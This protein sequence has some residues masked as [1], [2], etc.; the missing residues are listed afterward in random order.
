MRA[1]PASSN[2]P[3]RITR[4]TRQG[5][6]R[7]LSVNRHLR[8]RGPRR[9]FTEAVAPPWATLSPD[10]PDNAF[11]SVQPKRGA[12]LLHD[13][14]RNKGTAFTDAERDALGLRGL[15]PP[16]VTTLDEQLARVLGTV[17]AKPTPLEQ[18][19][20]LSALHDRN[21]TLFYRLLVD[22]VEEL[23][24]V[25]YTPTVGEACQQWGRIFRRG[26][27]LYI[28]A[29]DRGRLAQ[30][31]ANWPHDDV[32]MIVVT[33]GERI[34]G[35]G[36]LGAHGMGIPVGKLMLYT[37]CAGIAPWQCL[38]ITLDVGTETAALRDDP[39]YVGR[40]V[41][42]LR[43]PE[44]DALVDEF[45]DAVQQRFPRACIQFEDFGNQNA[46]R[47]LARWR[48]RVCTFND[49]IQG[50]AAVA[51]AGL[52]S[53]TRVTGAPLTG[54]RLLFFGAGEAGIGIGDLVVDALM[55]E[56][57]SEAT[58]RQQC[59]FMDSKG[60]VVQSRDD[61]AEHK[62]PFAHA[63]PPVND[64]LAA[65]EALTPHA[66]IGVSGM[67]GAFTAPVLA[68]MARRHERPI[69]L[70]LS[71]PTSKS[72]CT[73][74]AAYAATDG[75]ALF[76]SGSPFA[77]VTHAGVTHVPGQGNNAYIF[78]GVGLGLQ[79][80]EASRVTNEMFAAAARTLAA[81]ATA[82]DLRVGRLYPELGRI[83]EVSQ[84]IAAEVARVAYAQG[85]A[86]RPRPTDLAHAA[87]AL[88]YDPRYESPA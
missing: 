43:G 22:H 20:Y 5:D 17:R 13:P 1:V 75:R 63:H 82:D 76:A 23:M 80:S 9:G 6:S 49:D 70:A 11:V 71:N 46:F 74:E 18:Y 26:Q 62:R 87:Q 40:A 10:S 38:P 85:L 55:S 28:T 36:D 41:P 67:A 39:F 29:D 35:L 15:L 53:A 4:A 21:E 69:V 51:L 83:R 54:M 78:P 57:V 65:V 31:L 64:L 60:L 81:H 14:A 3:R 44:Y 25:L 66:L 2:A 48:D 52:C 16:R 8:P 7:A 77:P 59:W 73:A 56:G 34:L 61:L 47:L 86:R 58:A 68:A 72:E 33:D 32:R 84:A 19:I 24:P 12:D 45:V 42:R 79:V 88:M 27:G 37:A 30:V 50:T